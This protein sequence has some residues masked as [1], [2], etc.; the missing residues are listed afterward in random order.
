MFP[1]PPFHL[2][3][4]RLGDDSD[5]SEIDFRDTSSECSSDGETEKLTGKDRWTCNGQGPKSSLE[6][7]EEELLWQEEDKPES[8]V[9]EYF[10]TAAPSL[11]VPLYDKV[12]MRPYF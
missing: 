11:R 1:S 10:E 3:P 8:L 12:R 5:G 4:R 2:L 7:G 6:V 9:Y